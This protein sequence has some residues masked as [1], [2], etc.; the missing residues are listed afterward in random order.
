MFAVLVERTQA[1]VQAAQQAALI[2]KVLGADVEVPMLDDAIARLDQFVAEPPAVVDP[3][4]REL[5]SALGL[6]VA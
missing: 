2:A 1:H 5:R 6:R 4:D 3:A